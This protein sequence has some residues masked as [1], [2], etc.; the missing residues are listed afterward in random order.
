MHIDYAGSKDG[1]TPD[2]NHDLHFIQHQD[3]SMTVKLVGMH[4]GGTTING[5]D[6]TQAQM[7]HLHIAMKV[8]VNG[9]T[10]TVWLTT[11]NG[12]L[13]APKEFAHLLERRDFDTLQ[14]IVPGKNGQHWTS[15]STVV[16]NGHHYTAHELHSHVT[17]LQNHLETVGAQSGAGNPAGAKMVESSTTF[18]THVD[19]TGNHPV[20]L[21]NGN[22]QLQIGLPGNVLTHEGNHYFNIAMP[23]GATFNHGHWQLTHAA[24]EHINAALQQHGLYAKFETD[25][26]GNITAMHIDALKAGDKMDL[27]LPP[28]YHAALTQDQNGNKILHI[29]LPNGK[30]SVDVKVDGAYDKTTGMLN[31]AK[32]QPAI[33]SALASK[34]VAIAFHGHS[35]A[36]AGAASASASPSAT[37]SPAASASATAPTGTA[38]SGSTAA[39]DNTQTA[40]AESSGGGGDIPAWVGWT[41]LAALVAGGVVV[42]AERA[43]RRGAFNDNSRFRRN[44]INRIPAARHRTEARETAQQTQAQAEQQRQQAATDAR[45]AARTTILNPESDA[46]D[47][48]LTRLKNPDLAAEFTV[49]NAYTESRESV[50]AYANLVAPEVREDGTSDAET[51]VRHL[52]DLG[53][54]M[55][56]AQFVASD[57]GNL[58]IEDTD[59]G[60]SI[61]AIAA[62]LV[63]RYGA[64]PQREAFLGNNATREALASTTELLNEYEGADA[65]RQVEIRAQLRPFVQGVLDRIANGTPEELRTRLID[66]MGLEGDV[67]QDTATGAYAFEDENIVEIAQDLT[68]FARIVPATPPTPPTPP[69]AA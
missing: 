7:Q 28:G 63:D 34:H 61:K 45:E 27:Q 55:R 65:G 23:D 36:A 31:F 16:G 51:L 1:V 41:A 60:A 69:P 66:S 39:A 68:A 48:L 13:H 67:T 18:N 24:Q 37:R 57:D 22:H 62:Q 43:R 42:V 50:N 17:N 25:K 5:H 19:L 15:I 52:R 12:T 29:T 14:E 30:G 32:L 53:I 59:E 21:Q 6:I 35:A 44:V 54:P 8:N 46:A 26:N 3:G 33:Q 47:A 49:G 20:L 4:E 64:L 40:N 11:H 56:N 58:T 2:A 10:E 38:S 9:H